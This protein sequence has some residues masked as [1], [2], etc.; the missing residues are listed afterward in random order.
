VNYTCLGCG[1]IRES[2]TATIFVLQAGH[3][4]VPGSVETMGANVIDARVRAPSMKHP[5]RCCDVLISFE[6][7]VEISYNDS[8]CLV[9][10]RVYIH[11]NVSSSYYKEYIYILMFLV[12]VT[13]KSIYDIMLS[14]LEV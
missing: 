9:L 3:V 13:I 11:I 12:V 5:V 7:L 2:K 10:Q 14:P 6:L 1:N 8:R 4:A